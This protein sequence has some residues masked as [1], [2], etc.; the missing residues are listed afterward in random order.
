M[1]EVRI[2][3]HSFLG[4]SVG[5][6]HDFYVR[7]NLRENGFDLFKEI[8]RYDDPINMQMVFR[9]KEASK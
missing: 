8:E 7:E 6:E 2:D 3:Y 1:K 5:K 9:Q 4:R